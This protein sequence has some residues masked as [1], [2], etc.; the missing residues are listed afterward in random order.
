MAPRGYVPPLGAGRHKLGS[1][2]LK[3]H[4]L[5]ILLLLPF[6]AAHPFDS[7]YRHARPYSP[8]GELSSALAPERAQADPFPRP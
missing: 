4:A 7:F 5:H 2:A 3:I 8:A 6:N 1:L